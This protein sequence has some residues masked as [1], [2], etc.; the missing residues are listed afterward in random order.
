MSNDYLVDAFALAIDAFLL[1]DPPYRGLPK[2]LRLRSPCYF[3]ESVC[4]YGLVKTS[5]SRS[6]LGLTEPTGGFP[7]PV[8]G[9]TLSAWEAEPRM[10]HT[11]GEDANDLPQTLSQ[12]TGGDRSKHGVEARCDCKWHV[13]HGTPVVSRALS[14]PGYPPNSSIE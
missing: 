1:R 7:G 11:C 13:L 9:G 4:I 14:D 3:G 12:T 8:D 2:D 10:Y 6:L 5:D